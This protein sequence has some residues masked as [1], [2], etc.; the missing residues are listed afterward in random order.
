MVS[1]KF[2]HAK[3]PMSRGRHST[4]YIGNYAHLPDHM[5]FG[6]T[7]PPRRPR[8]ADGSFIVRNPQ[9]SAEV[10]RGRRDRGDLLVWC[11]SQRRTEPEDNQGVQVSTVARLPSASESVL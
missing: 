6:H 4:D 9:I 1:W 8:G 3:V 11:L 10:R 2:E 5:L 7:T